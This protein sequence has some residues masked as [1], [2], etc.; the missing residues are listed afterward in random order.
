MADD[1]LPWR[2]SESMAATRSDKVMSRL[3][4]ISF[5]PFQ[6]ASSRLTLVLC[7]A[8][9]MDRFTTGDFIDRLPFPRGAGRDRGGPWCRAPYRDCARLYCGRREDDWRQLAPP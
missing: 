2:R 6:N 5:N 1:R 4:A 9:T 8:I 7:P 3:P